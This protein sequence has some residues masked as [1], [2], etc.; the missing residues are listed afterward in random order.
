M[1][2]TT[3][4]KAD[5]FGQGSPS[6]EHIEA[7]SM[8]VNSSER[9]RLAFKEQ[10]EPYLE[11]HDAASNLVAGL[12]LYILGDYAGAIL[13]LEKAKDSQQKCMYLARSL[14]SVGHYDNALAALDTAR[15]QHIDQL[16]VTLERIA[17]L[18]HA[19][20]L[21]D[22][23]KEL[24]G[25]ANFERIS[26][27]YHYQAGRLKDAQG[28]YDEAMK[29][30][31]AA[32]QLE[33]SHQRAIFHLAY[34][35]DL[36]GNDEDAIEY[37]CQIVSHS[38]VYTSSLLNLAIL[39]ED[40]GEYEDAERCVNT[41]LKSHPNHPRAQLFKKDIDS[42]K[43]MFY[44]EERE[45]KLD[46]RNQILEIPLSD[47]ELSVRSRNCLRKMNLRTIGDLL[48]TSEIELLAYKNFG[49]TSLSEIKS[50]LNSKNLRLGMAVEDKS[51]DQQ[52]MSA[53]NANVNE[54]LLK[55]MVE[56]FDMS[57]RVK[58]CLHRLNLHTI[59]D[60]VSRTEAELLGCKNFGATSLN[61]IKEKLCELGLSLRN[62][63]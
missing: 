35:C 24:K 7:V 29:H 57:V 3:A 11:K 47:F 25:C 19:G 26:A 34:N 42:S 45:R 23:A 31:H 2:A 48:R 16:K 8:S 54:E 55:K 61:E 46:R 53:S 28:F 15:G 5:I 12:G 1:S 17:L 27:E 60:I 50:I 6:L 33:P 41:V 4:A 38:P 39:Y 44:D 32:I 30:Y 22:A 36:R 18:R 21:N 58:K 52:K 10:L 9:A 40:L 43:T 49:E 51:L 59:G 63:E 13:K 14:C 62:L 56:D 20:R 37:Y